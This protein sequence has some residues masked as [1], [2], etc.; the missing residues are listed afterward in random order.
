MEESNGTRERAES[1]KRSAEGRGEV[2]L[3]GELRQRLLEGDALGARLL[4]EGCS[5]ARV[6]RVLEALEG[7]DFEA[8]LTVVDEAQRSD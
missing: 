2:P 1:A 4:L 8:A 3:P 7:Y 6:A 5:G